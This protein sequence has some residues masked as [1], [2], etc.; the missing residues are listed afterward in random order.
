MQGGFLVTVYA[1]WGGG[2][3]LAGTV[4]ALV[5]MERILVLGVQDDGPAGR[6]GRV[7][8]CEMVALEEQAAEDGG[9]GEI[10]AV[11]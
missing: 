2:C 11:G 7:V 1:S 8:V 4:T 10:L 3:I 9:Y 5:L 6:E